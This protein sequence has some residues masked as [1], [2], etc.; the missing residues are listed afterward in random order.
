MEI[1]TLLTFLNP[2]IDYTTIR[3]LSIVA[4]A[5]LSM[6]GRVTMRGI[7]R[8]TEEPGSYRT[9]QRLFYSKINWVKLRWLF[10]RK[11]LIKKG[12]VT[13]IGGDDVIVSKSGKETHGLGRYF[14]SLQNQTISG[15]RFLALS[16]ISVGERN[17][18]PTTM[19]Q[20]VKE[21]SSALTQNGKKGRPP[22]GN[23]NKKGKRGRPKGSR[24][25]NRKDVELSPYLQLVQAAIM[26][27]LNLIGTDLSLVYFVFDGAFGNNAAL[28]MVRQCNLH[29]ISKLRYDSALYFPY[30]GEYC[31]RGRPI[32]YGDK[33]NCKKIPAEYLKGCEFDGDIQTYTCCKKTCDKAIAPYIKQQ[34]LVHL[35]RKSR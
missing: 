17:S 13:L 9:V 14:S 3:H 5:I 20:I 31:G 15:L 11:H 28:Q 21:K 35:I 26:E 23:C 18:Y 29:L 7:S 6:S 30:C 16:L 25:K 2:T 34:G 10:I 8:W 33:L 27:L 24:N 1:I 19:E 12:D 32:Q 4:E 22:K